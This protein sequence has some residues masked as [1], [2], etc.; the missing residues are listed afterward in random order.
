MRKMIK[1]YIRSADICIE[2]VSPST[3]RS[4]LV[5]KQTEKSMPTESGG[6]VA[7]VELHAAKNGK[8]DASDERSAWPGS[9]D[10]DLVSPAWTNTNTIIQCMKTCIVAK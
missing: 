4:M 8:A 3:I 9:P 6:R 10:K 2:G 7:G 5:F 1:G